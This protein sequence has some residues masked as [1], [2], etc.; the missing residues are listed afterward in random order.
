MA[1]FENL[2]DWLQET[3]TAFTKA[4]K[5]LPYMAL[6]ANKGEDTPF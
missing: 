6:I 5:P 4:S 2:N 1:A 3:K